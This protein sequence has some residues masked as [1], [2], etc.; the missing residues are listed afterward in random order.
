MIDIGPLEQGAWPWLAVP[1]TA[2]LSALAVALGAGYARRRRLVDEPGRRRLHDV[3]TPRGAGVGIV[4]AILA[5]VVGM[6]AWKP[7]ALDA[8]LAAC[9]AT[10]MAAVAAVG[11]YDDHHGLGALPRIFVHVFAAA[12]F[13][14]AMFAQPARPEM[15]A[16]FLQ[17][18]IACGALI[19][20]GMV[21][22]T[23][24]HNFMDGID[25]LL[26][27]QALFVFGTLA[28]AGLLGGA[29]AFALL[30]A[31]SAAAVS[32]FLPFNAP[33]ASVF[34]GDVGSGALGFLIAAL[35]VI[36]VVRGVFDA[37]VA[38]LVPSAFVVDAG[39]T[40]LSRVVRGRRWY[41]AHRE[42]LYQWLARAGRTHAAVARLYMAWNLLVVVPALLAC[43]Y[44]RPPL[45]LV[46]CA[47]VYV[48]AIVTWW[49]VKALCLDRARARE[50]I[51]APA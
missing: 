8:V 51:H 41:S 20:I 35:L 48:A 2:L 34:M 10:G 7:P 4:I 25:G 6:T 14:V 15:A 37:P 27:L 5:A 21:A 1:A 12:V 18:P 33:R 9:L 19:V 44:L 47:L 28:L 39:M 17:Y 43:A 13:A 30:C 45:G 32:G 11:W 22:S 46:A 31:L 16:A 38:M 23:N 36:G 49:R 40:L 50:A 3:A 42:H 24:L 26:A 29:P